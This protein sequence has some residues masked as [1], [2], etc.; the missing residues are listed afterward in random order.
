[1]LPDDTLDTNGDT[2][3]FEDFVED[4]EGE[5]K[6]WARL[7]HGRDYRAFGKTFTPNEYV[8]VTNGQAAHLQEQTFSLKV[9]TNRDKPQRINKALFDLVQA[10]E[11]PA[12]NKGGADTLDDDEVDT[13][14][15]AARTRRR[16]RG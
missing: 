16:R 11:Q 3:D 2:D 4:E 8:E 12:I 14:R 5:T 15:K 10:V 9:S 7:A 1:M 6:W 13:A